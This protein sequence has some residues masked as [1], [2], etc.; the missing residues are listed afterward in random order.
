MHSQGRSV[1]ELTSC[2][3]LL[4][5]EDAQ[6]EVLI[7]QEGIEGRAISVC[8]GGS[9]WQVKG[10]SKEL[11]EATSEINDRARILATCLPCKQSMTLQSKQ[12]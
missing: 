4:Q 10:R 6:H 12:R 3:Q 2:T 9:L 11:I 7:V 5:R 1:G 8:N